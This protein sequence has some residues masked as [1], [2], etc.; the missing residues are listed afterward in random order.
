M[1]LKS[2]LISMPFVQKEPEPT[3]EIEN[4]KI[5]LIFNGIKNPKPEDVIITKRTFQ[6]FARER[7]AKDN[8]RLIKFPKILDLLIE[9]IHYR[10]TGKEKKTGY[11]QAT[12][13]Q[14]SVGIQLSEEEV[15]NV[16]LGDDTV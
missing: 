4:P 10:W 8:P 16:M 11:V 7:I 15:H 3:P 9:L 2:K 1:G 6:E 12:V 14:I 13:N 5:D